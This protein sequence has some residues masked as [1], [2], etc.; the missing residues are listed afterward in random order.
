MDIRT[1]IWMYSPASEYLTIDNSGDGAHDTIV[2]WR[3]AGIPEPTAQD[4]IDA[5]AAYTDAAANGPLALNADKTQISGDG[6]DTATITISYLL[7]YPASIDVLVN[8]EA[9]SVELVN[10]VG[11]LELVSDAPGTAI[12]IESLSAYQGI[13]ASASVSVEVV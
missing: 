8:G 7:P 1:K 10:G 12:L 9:V 2:E 3:D 11:T 5:Q 6:V 4:L 13:D